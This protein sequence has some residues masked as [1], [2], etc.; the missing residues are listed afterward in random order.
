MNDREFELVQA[1]ERGMLNGNRA[2]GDPVPI[3]VYASGL[4]AA[5]RF[6]LYGTGETARRDRERAQWNAEVDAK[7]AAKR[8]RVEP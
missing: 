7:K 3:V 5:D 2:P 4:S 8:A 1:I 6:L